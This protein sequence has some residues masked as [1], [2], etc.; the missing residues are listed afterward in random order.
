M[1]ILSLLSGFAPPPSF[2]NVLGGMVTRW[3]TLEFKLA[4]NGSHT[5]AGTTANGA[6]WR[7]T[8]ETFFTEDFINPASRGI[9]MSA[10]SQKGGVEG[11]SYLYRLR[12]PG[13]G[14]S[15]DRSGASTKLSLDTYVLI[16]DLEL[17]VP[18]DGTWYFRFESLE[19]YA[20]G[21][22][23]HSVGL[24]ELPSGIFPHAAAIPL[25][26]VHP[27][28]E[29]GA[30]FAG[31]TPAYGCNDSTTLGR[32]DSVVTGGW[33]WKTHD[34]TAWHNPNIL[35]DGTALLTGPEAGT[36]S[37]TNTYN[38]EVTAYQEWT[39]GVYSQG[40]AWAMALPD[41]TTDVHKV[42]MREYGALVY[43]GGFP[44]MPTRRFNST[45]VLACDLEETSYDSSTDDVERYPHYSTMLRVVGDAADV[46][47]D[48]LS[49]SRYCPYGVSGAQ[50]DLSG[51]SSITVT[52]VSNTLGPVI[53]NDAGIQSNLEHPDWKATFMNTWAC[54]FY[55][56][57]LWFPP[58]DPEDPVDYG[59][60]ANGDIA[61]SETYWYP[62]RQQVLD[63]PALDPANARPGVRTNVYLDTLDQNGLAGVVAALFGS[64]IKSWWGTRNW[65]PLPWDEHP[66]SFT[67]DNEALWNNATEAAGTLTIT[68]IADGKYT[69]E[70]DIANF[71]EE[72]YLADE[73]CATIQVF[74]PT[75]AS[76]W[77]VYAVGTHPNAVVELTS[78][79][80]TFNAPFYERETPA[81]TWIQDFGALLMVDQGTDINGASSGSVFLDGFKTGATGMLPTRTFTKLRFE[82]VPANPA[83]SPTFQAPVLRVGALDTCT[84]II[85][86]GGAIQLIRDNEEGPL[87]RWGDQEAYDY[88]LDEARTQPAF[89]GT[90]YAM[91]P[92]DY[93]YLRGVRLEGTEWG[94]GVLAKAQS[95]FYEGV[96]FIILDHLARDPDGQLTM[97]A[98]VLQGEN[99]PVGLVA[100][101]Y[102]SVPPLSTFPHRRANTDYEFPITQPWCLDVWTC[103]EVRNL[104]TLPRRAGSTPDFKLVD[105]GNTD[106][107]TGT[108]DIDGYLIRWHEREHDGNESDNFIVAD[109]QRGRPYRGGLWIRNNPTRVLAHARNKAQI[110]A[111]L[112]EGTLPTLEVSGNVWPFVWIT[113]GELSAPV[114]VAD[115]VWVGKDIVTAYVKVSGGGYARRTRT[116]GATWESEMLIS[117]DAK[118]IDCCRHDDNSLLFVWVEETAPSTYE[119]YGATYDSELNLLEGPTAITDGSPDLPHPVLDNV[120]AITVP[121]KKKHWYVITYHDGAGARTIRSVKP[122]S[123]YQP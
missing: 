114:E 117:A 50:D 38:L 61:P 122:L 68:S 104:H 48:P 75:N 46:I 27:I 57:A 35:L 119:L 115:L 92:F 74:A 55:S 25:V 3:Q 81:G 31:A 58:Y 97:I 19:W 10:S 24:T 103:C 13:L 34:D 21:V 1:P 40:T 43:R 108:A 99:Y 11:D 29:A 64:P 51:A 109:I 32:I 120:E 95:L 60:R 37:G 85:E 23:E 5:T 86:H 65:K 15:E 49:E 84:H 83:V 33:R 100:N 17:L 71:S 116:Q 98:H 59:W 62:N 56:Y 4:V 106:Q 77:K 44:G 54:P 53:T 105:S 111:R 45:Q 6:S 76:S 12:I 82:V 89:R 18:L 110:H 90:M 91:T 69:A 123:G 107:F 66:S 63:H 41:L 22:L 93:L 47:E 78:T 113:Q 80:G 28:L 121:T 94:D 79:A 67:L 2:S 8:L 42:G 118:Q 73:A 14:V 70:V 52:T 20:D 16:H 26:G 96:D 88:V 36:V 102:A 72:P 30:G 9:F 7:G 101:T 39:A 87:V 112:V